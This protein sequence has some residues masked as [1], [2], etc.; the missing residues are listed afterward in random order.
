MLP[1]VSNKGGRKSRDAKKR[2]SLSSVYFRQTD[3]EPKTR[4]FLLSEDPLRTFTPNGDCFNLW[5]RLK[6]EF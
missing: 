4:Q 2:P 6:G 5:C 1:L 3:L